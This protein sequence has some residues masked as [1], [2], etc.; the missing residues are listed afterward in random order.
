MNPEIGNDFFRA[1]ME[2]VPD[3]FRALSIHEW[4]T[5]P[6]MVDVSIEGREDEVMRWLRLICGTE[7]SPMHGKSGV[8][9]RSSVTIHNF[10]WFGFQ[11][12]TLLSRFL[13]AFPTQCHPANKLENT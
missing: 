4:T 6:F 13:K 12:E 8:W 9:K 1:C 10:S 11:T 3:E 2:K 7:S 5:T